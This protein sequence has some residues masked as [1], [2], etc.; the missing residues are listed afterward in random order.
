MSNTVEAPRNVTVTALYDKLPT[1][2]KRLAAKL[3]RSL[4]NSEVSQAELTKICRTITRHTGSTRVKKKVTGYILFY[5]QNFRIFK[6]SMPDASLGELAKA[7]STKWRELP[8][9]SKDSF[10]RRAAGD[11]EYDEQV[12]GI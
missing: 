1:R 10:N 4:S 7:I 5:S 2:E 12:D 3:I 9:K 11:T 8:Q 6:S